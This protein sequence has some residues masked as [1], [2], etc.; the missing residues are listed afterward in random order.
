MSAGNAREMKSMGTK[1]APFSSFHEAASYSDVD[2]CVHCIPIS[3]FS[4]SY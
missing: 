3:P 4:N 1:A 2:G